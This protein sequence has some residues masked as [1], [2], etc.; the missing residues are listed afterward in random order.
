MIAAVDQAQGVTEAA[1]RRP[2]DIDLQQPLVAH[3]AGQMRS[4]RSEGSARFAGLAGGKG[5][6]PGIVGRGCGALAAPGE[7]IDADR[8]RLP[9]VLLAAAPPIGLV[10]DQLERP[11][12][13]RLTRVPGKDATNLP[14]TIAD[15]EADRAEVGRR[16]GADDVR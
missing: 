7:R 14:G 8:R 5:Q 1:W 2:G 11:G 9:R 16:V 10:P 3:R 13:A 12:A 15:R 6:A 4:Q